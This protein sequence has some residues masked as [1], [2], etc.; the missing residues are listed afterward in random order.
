MTIMVTNDYEGV[1]EEAA[2]VEHQQH[3]K[4]V[5]LWTVWK[6]GDC[7]PDQLFVSPG[8]WSTMISS[9]KNKLYY[10]VR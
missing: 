1:V 4:A 5:R 3:Q 7:I 6:S 2:P 10:F 8:S 9:H